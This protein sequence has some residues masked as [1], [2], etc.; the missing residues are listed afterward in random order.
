MR[1]VQRQRIGVH[2]V[3]PVAVGAA[4]YVVWRT[5]SLLVFRWL[6]LLG[7]SSAAFEL[8]A[9]LGGVRAFLP[10]IV[11]FSGPD[12]LWVYALTSA[13]LLIWRGPTRSVRAWLWISAGFTISFVTE[14]GQ[15]LG[16]FPGTFDSADLVCSFAAA[17]L[18]IWNLRGKDGDIRCVVT[19]SA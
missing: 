16:G 8:R 11:L 13:M 15:A 7:L 19:S 4:I 6:E 10:R 17:L 18:A 3:L 2:V 9:L 1:A 5:P 12:A 14:L